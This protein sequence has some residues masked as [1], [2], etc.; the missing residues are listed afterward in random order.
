MASSMGVLESDVDKIPIVDMIDVLAEKVPTSCKEPIRKNI[1][2]FTSFHI[3]PHQHAI[4]AGTWLALTIAGSVLTYKRF[5]G[6]RRI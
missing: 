6:G 4:Y 5:R 2:S 3:M 1:E